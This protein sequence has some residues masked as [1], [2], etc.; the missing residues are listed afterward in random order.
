MTVFSVQTTA[1][2]QVVGRVY[3]GRGLQEALRELVDEHGL[4]TGW[5]NALGAFAWIDLTE[6]SQTVQ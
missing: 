5:L 1:S 6:Y 2:R 4:Q 3:R